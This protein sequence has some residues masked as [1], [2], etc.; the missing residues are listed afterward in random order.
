MV[1][2][3]QRAVCNDLFYLFLK[4]ILTRAEHNLFFITQGGYSKDVLRDQQ[5]KPTRHFFIFSFSR[6]QVIIE[7]SSNENLFVQN[8][9]VFTQM[10]IFSLKCGCFHSNSFFEPKELS[11]DDI[12][13]TT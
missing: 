2:L 8:D 13:M 1:N 11:F 9:K 4:I 12:L 5:I 6:S 7:K 10:K 3:L